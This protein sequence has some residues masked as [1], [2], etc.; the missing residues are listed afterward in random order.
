[1]SRAVGILTSTGGFVSHAAVVARGWGIPAVV[2]ASEV[3]LGDGSVTIGGTVLA[4]GDTITIDGAT[5][6][7]FAG[8]AA[9]V[10]QVVPEAAVLLGWAR[11]L[12]IEIEARPSRTMSVPVRRAG[13]SGGGARDGRAA[14]RGE[15]GAATRQYHR[16]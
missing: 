13:G 1:M 7:V 14:G 6:D 10:T 11:D 3:V 9:G 12:G 2:G 16:G 4:V 5:G 15:R 8:A